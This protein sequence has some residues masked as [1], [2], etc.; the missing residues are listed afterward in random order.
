MDA[1]HA[2]GQLPG[3]PSSPPSPPS[4]P[5]S[6][7]AERLERLRLLCVPE[8][9]EEAR[10]RLSGGPGIPDAPFSVLVARRLAELRA[11]CDLANHLRRR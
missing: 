3:N 7:V 1:P 11:L 10:R 8:R 2:P 6:G 5:L 4:T 9:V